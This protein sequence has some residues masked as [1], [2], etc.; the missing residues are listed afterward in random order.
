[1]PTHSDEA[2][3]VASLLARALYIS[4]KS[5]LGP[6]LSPVLTAGN[7]GCSTGHEETTR[8][9][10]GRY[11]EQGLPGFEAY[12]WY[13]IFLPKRTPAPIIR[14]LHEATT[15][16]MNTQA[17]RAN[18]RLRRHRLIRGTVRAERDAYIPL[19]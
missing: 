1:M 2:L 13:A 17:I 4:F 11:C 10:S 5:S 9:P 6:M 12:S 19:D 16:T 18:T 8:S 7:V 14:T 3:A 15:A